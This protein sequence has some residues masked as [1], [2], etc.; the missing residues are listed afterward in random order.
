MRSREVRVKVA[1][2]AS[3]TVPMQ[4][5]RVDVAPNALVDELL[6]PVGSLSRATR[7]GHGGGDELDST[8]VRLHVLPPER[9]GVRGGEVRLRSE[10]GLVEAEE[11]GAS[12]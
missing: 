8:G 5:D 9:D 1:N 10:V 2:V 7:V 4:G 6:E 12:S 11:M 3:I